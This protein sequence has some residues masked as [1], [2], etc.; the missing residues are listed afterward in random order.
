MATATS[1]FFIWSGTDKN[2]RQTKGEIKAPSQAMARAQLRQKGI[3]PRSVRRKPKPLF[4]ARKKPIRPSDLAIFTRQ[5][6]TM[7]K[8]GV[9]LVQSFDIVADGLD[10]P[11]M[12]DL[13][14]TIKNDVAAGTGLATTLAKYPRHFDELFCSL[15]GA[16]ESAGTLE[17]MLD[18][19][20]TY[21]EKTEQLKAKI[22]KALTYPTAVVVVALVVS[23]I[24]LVKVVPQFAE[25]FSSFGADLPA[26]TL[27][28]LRLSDF[29]QSWWFII[30]AAIIAGVYAFKE[31]RLR[32]KRFGEI[33]DRLML[34]APIFGGIVHNAV[35]ARFARTLAT[36][37]NA[38]V[39]LVEA[40]ESTAGAAGNSV[41]S[42]AILQIRDDV[43]T[44][45]TLY[46]SVKTTGLFPNMLLQM[47][48]IGEE[49]GQLDEMLDKVANHYED[50]VDNA[51]DGLSSLM[52]PM[53]MSILG[54][55]VGGLMIAMY[56]PIFMLGSVI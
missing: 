14:N 9:P 42:K 49:S 25:T 36:T 54:V 5:L 41:Y 6:A 24:L 23:G 46:Q 13:V 47:I 26:F 33:I 16:G 51:V 45:Q 21:K 32:S 29:M 44:G 28:V 12:R 38:G 7:M 30:L 15:V 52:E 3:N 10:N 22:K 34:K 50:A 17:V 20:A 18:R 40:L 35:V 1:E 43:T 53:I 37:F 39:P 31:L 8:A 27:F 56:L 55:L 48:S 11:S 19:V 2:G 4:R